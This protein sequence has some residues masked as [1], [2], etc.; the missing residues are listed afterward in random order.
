[1]LSGETAKGAFP[2]ESVKMM[3]RIAESTEKNLNGINLVSAHGYFKTNITNAIAFAA[4]TTALDL[5]SPC[6]IAITNSGITARMI[7]KFRP[8]A[9][10]VAYTQS[11]TIWRQINLAW[12]CL[13]ILA[14]QPIDS[15]DSFKH[16]LDEVSARSICK[17]GDYVVLAAGMPVGIAGAT[18][19]LK[20]EIVGNI[21]VKGKGIGNRTVSGTSNIVK[22]TEQAAR[23][24]KKGDI[25]VAT[26]TNNDLLPYIK[27][28]GALIV[29]SDM[30]VDYSHAETVARA[31]DIPIII[32]NE[33]V[34]DLIPNG[35]PI[36]VDS[37]FGFVY[38]GIRV[39][40]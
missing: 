2:A 36:T 1:M 12:G 20:V 26:K 16:A 11:E 23:Y 22:V 8:S 10:I 34:V 33:K 6:I 13:P 39:A 21:L 3:A 40:K 37:K 5:E 18:N 29:G 30:P 17:R 27:K 38:N 9:A 14:K 19:L 24:F 7:S 35:C 4:C 25:L 15:E 32:C 31:L 28:C